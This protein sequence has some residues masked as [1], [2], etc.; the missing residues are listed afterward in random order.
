MSPLHTREYERNSTS[1]ILPGEYEKDASGRLD[2][3]AILWLVVRLC[4]VFALV[5]LIG[6]GGVALIDNEPANDD[7][8]TVAEPTKDA[9]T[10]VVLN[11]DCLETDETIEACAAAGAPGSWT[12]PATCFYSTTN[13]RPKKGWPQK[14]TADGEIVQRASTSCCK[15]YAAQDGGIEPVC[16]ADLSS[17]LA[18]R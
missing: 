12:A 1:N 13:P 4:V 5:S 2:V 18:D 10:G 6:C 15:A 14:R 9:G 17:C 7:S 8:G 3:G 11:P 16:C